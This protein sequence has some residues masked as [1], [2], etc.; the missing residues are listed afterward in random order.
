MLVQIF[1]SLSERHAHREFA[2]SDINYRDESSCLIEVLHLVGQHAA[3]LPRLHR[4]Q[5]TPRDTALLMVGPPCP[6][7][8]AWGPCPTQ[9]FLTSSEGGW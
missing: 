6:S 1:F 9:V 8:S 2:P 5:A 7:A 4:H 3:H